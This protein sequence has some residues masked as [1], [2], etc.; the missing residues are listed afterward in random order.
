HLTAD[1]AGF[2]SEL[3]WR[4]HEQARGIGPVQVLELAD[5]ASEARPPE[6]CAWPDSGAALSLAREAASLFSDCRSKLLRQTNG[7]NA[8]VA[9]VESVL[10]GA[11]LIVALEDST[12]LPEDRLSKLDEIEGLLVPVYEQ[13]RQSAHA[14]RRSKFEAVAR[15]VRLYEAWDALA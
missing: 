4:Q 2:L 6:P 15:L 9:E 5:S 11:L 8:H 1:L 3:A 13:L 14:D 12:L 7:P 10:G